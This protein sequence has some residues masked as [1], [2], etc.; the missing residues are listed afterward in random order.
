M[1]EQLDLC[2]ALFECFFELLDQ[3]GVLSVSLSE[4]LLRLVGLLLRPGDLP[5][6]S[7]VFG[8][9]FDRVHVNLYARALEKFSVIGDYFQKKNASP[10]QRLSEALDV[11]R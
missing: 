3:G 11:V 9:E 4:F 2:I 10:N 6:E 8:L 1:L 5:F 7:L